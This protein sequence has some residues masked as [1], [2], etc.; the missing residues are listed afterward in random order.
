MARLYIGELTPNVMEAGAGPVFIPGLGDAWVSQLEHFSKHYHCVTFDH[1]GAG[2]S[3]RSMEAD[4]YSTSALARDVIDLMDT[5]K[6]DKAHVVGTSTDGC[7]LEN[8]ALDH[9]Q[10]LRGC[11][12]NNT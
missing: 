3:D 4:A 12:F 9:P 6:I 2:D 5:L 11:I 8:L 7:V 10:R 1:R